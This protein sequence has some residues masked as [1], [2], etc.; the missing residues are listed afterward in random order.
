MLRIVVNNSSSAAKSYYTEGLSKNDYYTKE[1]ETEIVGLWGGKGSELLG[2]NGMV[3]QE[4]FNKL[5]DNINP[6]TDDKLTPRNNDNRRVGYDLNFHSPKSVSLVYAITKDEELLTAFRQSVKETMVE[7]EKDMQARVRKSN[8]NEN[9]T[10]GNIVYGEFIHTTSRPVD[11]VPDPHLHA[12]CF[13]FNATYDQK[14]QKWKAGEFGKIKKDASYFEAYFHSSFAGKLKDLGYQI[15]ANKKGW[16]ITGIE[17]STI[18]KFSRRTTEIEELAKEKGI[19]D[20]K[21]KDQLGA[22]TRKT[23]DKALSENDLVKTW[24][25]NLTDKEKTLILTAKGKEPE[26]NIASI[27]IQHV[28]MAISHVLERKSVASEREI[29]REALKRSIGQCNPAQILKS[30]S[31]ERLIKVKIKDDIL[32]TTTEAVNEERQLVRLA[33]DSKG[34][35]LPLNKNYKVQDKELNR[36]Q[37]EAINYALSSKDGIFI[38]EGAAGAGKTTLMKELKNAVRDSGKKLIPFAPSAEASRDVLQKEGF[39][40]ADTVAQL[41]LNT[42]LQESCRGNVIWI[43]EAGLLGNKTMNAAMEIAKANNA[44]LILTGDTKQHNSVERGDALRL[45]IEKSKIKTV[46]VDEIQRQK[47]NPAYK[48]VV[49]RITQNDFDRAFDGLEKMNAIQQIEDPTKRYSVIAKDFAASAKAKS[50]V[51]VVSPT[52]AEG[53]AVTKAIRLELKEQKL[54]GSQEHRITVQKNLSPTEIEKQDRNFYTIGMSIQF[55]QNA[56]GFK[57]GAVYDIAEKDCKGNVIVANGRVLQALPFHETGKF[58]VYERKE[59][60]LAKGDSIRITQ[61]GFSLNNKRLNNGNKLKVRGFD[62]NGNIIAHNGNQEIRLDKN[63]RNISYGY[64]STSHSSQGKTVDKVIIAQSGISNRAASKEQFYVSVSRGR[65]AISIYTNDKAELKRSVAHSSQ[66]MTATEIF[67]SKSHP[68]P[69]SAMRAKQI[70]VRR[71][72]ELNRACYER[73]VNLISKTIPRR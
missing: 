54:L 45:L 17:R 31:K 3:S 68:V 14:E 24:L 13:T 4:Q 29:L 63:Y 27:P 38:I 1:K 65:T 61:N 48:E 19:T 20:A 49:K 10:T 41:L 44:W 50:S 9:R 60:V 64:C 39:H 21:A 57:R 73:T 42:K 37:Q 23:K 62:E 25:S 12:H 8:G 59:I 15:E 46:R 18:E 47:K 69:N 55:H 34:K 51:L 11:G 71:L 56:K 33:T 2:L 52:H 16:E 72:T 35:F 5:C 30:F 7:I 67:N 53:E 36:E 58:S 28:D 66:R 32:L 6:E 22:K 43:D 70:L 40:A 26:S